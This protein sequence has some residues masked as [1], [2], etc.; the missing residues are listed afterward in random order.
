M[1]ID[2]CHPYIIASLL[3]TLSQPGSTY[4]LVVM[5]GNHWLLTTKDVAVFQLI[6]STDG[7]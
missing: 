3:S 6:S 2:C 1:E 5:T 7:S 4:D